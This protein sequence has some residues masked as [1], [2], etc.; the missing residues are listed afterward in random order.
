M[1]DVGMSLQHRI[2]HVSRTF[3][4]KYIL[5]VSSI[6]LLVMARPKEEKVLH[7]TMINVD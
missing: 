7:L 2:I 1:I 6:D 5:K 3:I 4:I